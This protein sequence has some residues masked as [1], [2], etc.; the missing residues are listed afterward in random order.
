MITDV[1]SKYVYVISLKDK[2]GIIITNASHEVLKKKNK[3]N[4]IIYKEEFYKRLIKSSLWNNKMKVFSTYNKGK[5]IVA[6][7]FIRTLK[8]KICIYTTSI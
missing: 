3:E 7:W 2:N 8:N 4:C 1:C 5:L 6:E